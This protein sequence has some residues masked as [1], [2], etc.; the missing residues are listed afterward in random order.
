MSVVMLF[1]D[2]VCVVGMKTVNHCMT[3]C[4]IHTVRSR[5]WEVNVVTNKG[6]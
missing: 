4:S 6:V 1:Y 5:K 2:Y 3:V